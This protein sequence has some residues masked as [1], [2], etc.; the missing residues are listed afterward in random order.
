MSGFSQIPVHLHHQVHPHVTCGFLL[1]SLALPEY[2][3]TCGFNIRSQM[4]CSA[5]SLPAIV[6]Q[7]VLIR[8]RNEIA[9]NQTDGACI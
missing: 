7:I 9:C 1:A 8:D 6:V 3:N 4:K 2:G 5:K